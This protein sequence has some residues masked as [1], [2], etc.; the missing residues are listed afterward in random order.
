MTAEVTKDM[1]ELTPGIGSGPSAISARFELQA[2][3]IIVFATLFLSICSVSC[4]SFVADSVS[5]RFDF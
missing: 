5:G 1:E 3:R 2:Y 4:H